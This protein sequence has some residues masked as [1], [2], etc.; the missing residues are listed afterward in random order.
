MAR[1]QIGRMLERGFGSRKIAGHFCMT[2]RRV[3]QICQEREVAGLIAVV[4]PALKPTKEREVLVSPSIIAT[5]Y[6]QTA[7]AQG[8]AKKEGDEGWKECWCGFK[9]PR[10]ALIADLMPA[11]CAC[12]AGERAGTTAS[13]LQTMQVIF[14]AFCRRHTE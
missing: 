10:H 5:P 1:K 8:S 7:F 13:D 12:A 3:Q 9:V 2:E 4:G 14:P 11:A 6:C